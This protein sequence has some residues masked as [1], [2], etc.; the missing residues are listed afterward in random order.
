[1]WNQMD[2]CDSYHLCIYYTQISS[3]QSYMKVIRQEP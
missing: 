1:M 3:S 2:S